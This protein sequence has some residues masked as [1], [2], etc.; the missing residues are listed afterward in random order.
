MPSS[1]WRATAAATMTTELTAAFQK[2]G[3]LKRST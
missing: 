1:T 3:S 2:N